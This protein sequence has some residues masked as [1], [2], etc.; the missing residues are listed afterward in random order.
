M[1]WNGKKWTK[2][3]TPDP[4]GSKNGD[5]NELFDVTCTSAASC[6]S[7][8]EFG[9]PP[10]VG[11]RLANQALHWNGR[12]WSRVLT[13][14]PGGTSAGDLNTLA[15]VRCVSAK[16]C[17]AVGDY[18]RA[19]GSTSRML[20]EALHWNG[21]RWNQAHTPNPGG[22]SNGNFSQL[23]ALGCGSSTSCWAAGSY[24]THESTPKSLNQILHWNGK[25][26]TK[27]VVPNPG[28][29]HGHGDL[30]IGATCT[31]APDC[32][33][34]GGYD[35]PTGGIVNEAMRWNGTKW[36]LVGTPNPAGTTTGHLN[37]LLGVRCTSGHNC[38]AVGLQ[39]PVSAIYRDE[40]LHWNGKKWSVE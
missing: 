24:G 14:N 35:S 5:L 3:S 39:E 33:G 2:V 10:S 25:K 13:P 7:V 38:W 18:A 1:H 21:V 6:W 27:F 8:G 23:D 30:L 32:G 36:S 29:G 4:G 22:K 9:N 40:I 28:T 19:S 26:W 37:I 16:D 12:A 20:N 34:V 17:N 11:Q 31:S 15:A